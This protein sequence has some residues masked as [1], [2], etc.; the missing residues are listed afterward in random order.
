M[1]GISGF[2]GLAGSDFKLPNVIVNMNDEMALQ[3][4][5]GEGFLFSGSQY[6]EYAGSL[7]IAKTHRPAGA[8][9]ILYRRKKGFFVPLNNLLFEEKWGLKTQADLMD[10][11]AKNKLFNEQYI[12]IILANKNGSLEL[13]KH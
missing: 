2:I 4:P 8:Q 12:N 1:Y 11:N 6:R 7:K 3:G 5:D 9:D 13:I 10:N